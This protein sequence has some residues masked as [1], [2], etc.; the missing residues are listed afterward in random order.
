MHGHQGLQGEEALTIMAYGV[1]L[2]ELAKLVGGALTGDGSVLIRAVNGLKEAVPG[3][4]SFLANP[5]YAPL[6]KT[7]RASAEIGRAHV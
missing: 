1:A 5:K 2:G 4:I 3:E 7:T 6:L